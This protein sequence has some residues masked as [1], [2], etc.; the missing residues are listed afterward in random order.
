MYFV[1]VPMT[2]DELGSSI[3]PEKRRLNILIIYPKL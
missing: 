1:Y 3:H 2:N